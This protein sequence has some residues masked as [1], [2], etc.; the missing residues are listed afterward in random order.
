MNNYF[1]TTL[2]EK[3]HY[4]YEIDKLG[5]G[6]KRELNFKDYPFDPESMPNPGERISFYFKN[7]YSIC[8][9]LGS[10]CDKRPGCESVFF[11]KESLTLTQLVEKIKSF[12]YMMEI[13]RLLQPIDDLFKD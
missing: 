10:P 8:A 1:G 12:P 4:F 11:F 7:G 5:I 6:W 3:G 2:K 13:I 9:I